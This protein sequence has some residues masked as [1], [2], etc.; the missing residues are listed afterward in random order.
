MYP[1][2]LGTIEGWGCFLSARKRRRIIERYASVARLTNPF[3]LLQGDAHEP[4]SARCLDPSE[5][6]LLSDLRTLI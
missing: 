2:E 4:Y 6:V 5:G 1:E 3:L